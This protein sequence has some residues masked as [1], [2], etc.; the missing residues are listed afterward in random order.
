MTII[1]R[2]LFQKKKIIRFKT[3]LHLYHHPDDYKLNTIANEVETNKSDITK[4]VNLL[5]EDGL[6]KKIDYRDIKLP[7]KGCAVQLEK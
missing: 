2:D 5:T 6:V 1:N 7:D 3:L 4:C